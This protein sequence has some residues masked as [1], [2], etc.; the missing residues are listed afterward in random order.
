MNIYS[1]FISI[2]FPN[3]CFLY[4]LTCFLY[5]FYTTLHF[6]PSLGHPVTIVLFFLPIIIATT[7]VLLLLLIIIA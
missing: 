5:M 2:F 7:T 6:L 4:N 3:M 1:I